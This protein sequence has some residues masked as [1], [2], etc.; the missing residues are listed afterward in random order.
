MKARLQAIWQL[1]IG[2]TA[3]PNAKS[4]HSLCVNSNF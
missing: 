1:A 2:T 4:T 3:A